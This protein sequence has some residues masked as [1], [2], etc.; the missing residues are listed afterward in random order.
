[1]IPTLN[2]LYRN[3]D[4]LLIEAHKGRCH[5][6]EKTIIDRFWDI[7]GRT[8]QMLQE[9]RYT[10]KAILER[11]VTGACYETQADETLESQNADA[12]TRFFLDRLAFNLDQPI[13]NENTALKD[14]IQLRART[15]HSTFFQAVVSF[16]MGSKSPS[17]T[18]F[19]SLLAGLWGLDCPPMTETD[20]EI[21]QNLQA[22]Q[23]SLESFIKS[24]SH[25]EKC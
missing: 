2:Q 4:C 15:I 5:E 11:A 12:R 18:P 23:S 13:C 7:V 17:Y 22:A 1:M 9:M 21:T 16:S 6:R 25:L 10:H 19:E 20:G 8:P 14:Y 3:I 24:S